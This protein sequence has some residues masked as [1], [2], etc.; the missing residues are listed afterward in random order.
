MTTFSSWGRPTMGA[1]NPRS[2]PRLPDHRDGGIKSTDVSPV[3]G[4]TVMC[5]TSMAAP[6][7]TGSVAIMRQEYRWSIIPA[8]TSGLR[9]PRHAIQ[10]ATDLG[11][12]GPDYQNGFGLVNIQAAV[13]LINRKG[14]SR[15]TSPTLV[16]N[17]TRWRSRPA[18]ARCASAWLG[19]P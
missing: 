19:R 13:D 7:V 5:G 16:G 2:S 6:S 11:N 8:A 3:D 18:P 15:P 9:A 14:W 4:Y 10:T 17:I 12:P 1:S